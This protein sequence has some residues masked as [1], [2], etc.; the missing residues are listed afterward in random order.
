MEER[1][2]RMSL[3]IS[4]D[5]LS[6]CHLPAKLAVHPLPSGF[7]AS[8][9]EMEVLNNVINSSFTLVLRSFSSDQYFALTGDAADEMFVFISVYVLL[10][11]CKYTNK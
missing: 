9:Q 6:S 10:L 3:I 2:D 11:G 1:A 7:S 5:V 4:S 8:G